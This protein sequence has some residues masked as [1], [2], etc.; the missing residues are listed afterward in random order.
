VIKIYVTEPVDILVQF[1]RVN[2][3]ELTRNGLSNRQTAGTQSFNG[4]GATDIFTLTTQPVCIKT[5]T[6]GGV[7]QTCYLHYEIDIDNK[8]IK[9]NAG[10]IPAVGTNNIVVTF[11]SGSTWVYPDKPRE[12]LKKSNYPRLG[13]THLVENS[14]DMGMGETETYDSLTF[15]IDVVAFKDQLCTVGSESIADADVAQYLARQVCKKIKR[16][17]ALIQNKL[18]NPVILNNYPVPFED[19]KHIVRRIIE[20]KYEANNAGE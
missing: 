8:K 13:V 11:D 10:Y 19:D 12:D 7:L 5:V 9:F 18:Y 2:V 4:D 14:Y 17:R 1:L 16:S 15:Q 3:T 6:V 20:V